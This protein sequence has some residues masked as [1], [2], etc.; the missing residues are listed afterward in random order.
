MKSR[1]TWAQRRGKG[2]K[3][4]TED[5]VSLR[6]MIKEGYSNASIAGT[7]AISERMVRYIRRGDCWTEVEDG[8]DTRTDS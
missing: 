7:F 8:T 1:E 5:M 2:H 6:Q 3:L 4:T